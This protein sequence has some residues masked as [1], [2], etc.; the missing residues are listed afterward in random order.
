[1][2]KADISTADLREKILSKS[3]Y[4][5][6]LP[7]LVDAL[8]ESERQKL[9]NEKE[10]LK[11]VSGKLHQVG[12]A[13]FNTRPDYI[14]WAAQLE[15]LP[16]DAHNEALKDFC[17]EAMRSHS[18]TSERL[19]ILE[20]F[21]QR[22]LESIAPV[23]SVLDLACGLNPLALDWMPLSPGA[24]Y[25]GCDIFSDMTGFLTAFFR[26]IEQPGDFTT[27]DLTKPNFR[28]SAKVAFLL[29]TLPCLEQLT[30]GI[31]KKLLDMIP[32]NYLLI[33]YPVRSLGGRAKGMGKTY[34]TQFMTLIADKRWSYQRF[35]FASELAFLVKKEPII[36]RHG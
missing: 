24:H 18:S 20:E 3:K 7:A 35:E 27:C 34:E 33:S 16:R 10:I 19:P 4:Q 5:S 36:E 11:A 32:V 8:I 31:H 13:Y 14:R 30:K 17:R 9:S 29:K 12:A 15:G 6:I 22:T 23:E 28:G 1:M 21:F 25:E 2:A 26:H